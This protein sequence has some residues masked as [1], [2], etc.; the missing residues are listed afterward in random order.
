MKMGESSDTFSHFTKKICVCLS[1]IKVSKGAE[2]F[3][4]YNK[5]LLQACLH[6]NLLYLESTKGAFDTLILS[7]QIEI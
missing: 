2:H 1:K 3:S 5:L 6:N 7:K 4:K